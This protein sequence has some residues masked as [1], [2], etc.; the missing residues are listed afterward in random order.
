MAG[1]KL[2]AEKKLQEEEVFKE[3]YIFCGKVEFPQD[4]RE[5]I[6]VRHTYEN[7]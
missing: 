5:E 7:Q 6:C 3:L 1:K 4:A 2:K